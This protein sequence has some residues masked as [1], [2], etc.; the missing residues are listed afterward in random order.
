MD[1]ES[2]RLIAAF[3]GLPS[4]RRLPN[5]RRVK[6]IGGL[7]DQLIQKHN[8]LQPSVEQTIMDNWRTII[9]GE[10]AHRCSPRKIVAEKTLLISAAN[11]VIRQE[12]VFRKNKILCQVQMLSGCHGIQGIS[13][14]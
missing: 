2:E 3:R 8:I 1:L 12:L 4:P 10:F 13:F 9:G 14:E 5:K 11:P 7:M 6:E